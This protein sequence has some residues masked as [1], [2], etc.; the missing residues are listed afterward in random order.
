MSF[1]AGRSL[2]KPQKTD[3]NWYDY[4]FRFYDPVLGRFPSLDPIADNFVELS[5]YNYASN[6][7]ITKIDLWGLQGVEFFDIGP[8]LER[9]AIQAGYY[10]DDGSF[11]SMQNAVKYSDR[12]EKKAQI[13]AYTAAGMLGLGEIGG[14][15]LEGL[16][17]LSNTKIGKSIPNFFGKNVDDV[18][19]NADNLS[20]GGKSQIEL[21]KEAGQV[22]EDFLKNTYGGQQQVSKSTTEGR[23][24]ID[25]LTDSGINQ[26]SKVGRTSATSRVKEQV[27]KDVRLMNDPTSGVK[28]VEWHF[29][30][31][32]TGVGP[33]NPLRNLLEKNNI[34][35]IIH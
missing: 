32:N 12:P 10:K 30:Q 25:N 16:P 29:F 23:R 35:I 8:E 6:N 14:A 22:G 9:W 24:V 5:P 18:T 33:T 3:V 28:K 26:E 15:L 20:L 11:P 21:N 4:G 17:A 27:S 13:D 19:K 1:G 2:E 34:P 31:S 7:P